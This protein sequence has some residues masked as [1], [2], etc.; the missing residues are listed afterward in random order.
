MLKNKKHKNTKSISFLFLAIMLIFINILISV[1][2]SYYYNSLLLKVYGFVSIVDLIIFVLLYKAAKK[3]LNTPDLIYNFGFGKYEDFAV[4]ISFLIM[5]IILIHL[6]F[7]GIHS[8]VNS[9]VINNSNILLIIPVVI[10]LL[11]KIKTITLEKFYKDSNISIFQEL[12]SKRNKYVNMEAFIIISI[13]IQ[14]F[15]PHT[16]ISLIVYIDIVGAL[17]IVIYLMYL[18]IKKIRNS[19]NQLLDKTLPEE[20]LFDFLTVIIEHFNLM[21]EYKSMRTRQSGE[22]IFVDIDIIMPSDISLERVSQI[23]NSIKKSLNK[24]YP[25][26]HPRVYAQPCVRNCIYKENGNCPI[27]KSDNQLKDVSDV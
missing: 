11:S 6:V 10:Y 20:I 14:A 5:P 22:D 1:S 9:V 19:L 24:K 26:V 18:P 15:I 23:E 21:C 4:V 16:L 2:A 8:V 13:L 25:N 7:N 17:I 27:L 3:S 12:V